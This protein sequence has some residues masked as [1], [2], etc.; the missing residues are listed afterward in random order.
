MGNDDNHVD[1]VDKEEAT[2]S[3]SNHTVGNDRSAILD[4]TEEAAEAYEIE[5]PAGD[6]YEDME[7]DPKFVA[8]LHATAGCSELLYPETEHTSHTRK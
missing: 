8:S 2:E 6:F 1:V 7:A 4:D 3:G 5:V